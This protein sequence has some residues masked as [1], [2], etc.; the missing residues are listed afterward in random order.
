MAFV[1]WSKSTITKGL[2]WIQAKENFIREHTHQLDICHSQ[3]S[4][5]PADL[6]SKEDKDIKHFTTFRD[7]LVPKPFSN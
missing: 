1:H 3:G 7:I 4:E 2:R 6:L 5:N